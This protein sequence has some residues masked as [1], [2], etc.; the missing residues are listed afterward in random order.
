LDDPMSESASLR[1]KDYRA[2]F[3]LTGECRELGVDPLAW[4][5]HLLRGA[6]QLAGAVAA[7][8]TE[9]EGF[10]HEP[11]FRVQL[12]VYADFDDAARRAH[13]R[14][15]A[16]QG[17][18]TIDQP[19]E[20]YVR[21]HRTL[22]TRSHEQLIQRSYWQRSV[23][24]NE[25]FRP[26]RFNDRLLS[27][28]RFRLTG[29]AG[30][31]SHHCFSLLRALGDPPFT[32]RDCRLIHLLHREVAPMIGRQLA[33][34][35]EPSAMQLSPQRRQVLECLLE[36]DGEKQI[37]ARLG[38]T[39]QTVHQY[40]KAVY[41]HFRINSRAELMARWIRFDRKLRTEN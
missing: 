41:R 2:V 17:F 25:Y 5:A 4:R 26:G 33:T 21:V 15:I 10:F 18:Y 31:S 7:I 16:E 13:Q 3:R 28:Y 32:R 6:N 19:L 27:G 29:G 36:G 24:F 20:Q 37:A 11:D 30:P 40:V 23:L 22:T 12:N 39:R 8:S 14:Y 35:N 1:P 9:G 38:L 34:A